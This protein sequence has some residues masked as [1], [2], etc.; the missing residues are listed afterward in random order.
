MGSTESGADGAGR[1]GWG[2]ADRREGSESE[3]GLRGRGR[4]EH[5][6]RL[7]VT[8][9]TR[10]WE[11]SRMEG[12]SLLGVAG[13]DPH[14]G[15]CAL[16]PP[17]LIAGPGGA[18]GVHRASVTVTERFFTFVLQCD[19]LRPKPRDP[20]SSKPDEAP[21]WPHDQAQRKLQ[22]AGGPQMSLMQQRPSH[23]PSGPNLPPKDLRENQMLPTLC[24]DGLTL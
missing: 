23:P 14:P 2:A 7:R 12:T 20:T 24:S 10:G 6:A 21:L 16:N 17:S 1:Q 8:V 9:S 19:N 5:V 11:Q 18:S 4:W 3:V 13:R 22:R 15:A